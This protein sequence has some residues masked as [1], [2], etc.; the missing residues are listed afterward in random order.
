MLP[1]CNSE[2]KG[3]QSHVMVLLRHGGEIR[4]FICNIYMFKWCAE[5]KGW[6]WNGRCH[7]TG[8]TGTDPSSFTSLYVVKSL[9][10]PPVALR[11]EHVV[12]KTSGNSYT[13]CCTWLSA[14]SANK[15]P[16]TDVSVLVCWAFNGF[17]PL[18]SQRKSLL[19]QRDHKLTVVL[20]K[21]RPT[22]VT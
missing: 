7:N 6:K 12:V 9:P 17:F 19:T 15:H 1:T 21:D 5:A 20:N 10:P 18:S 4:T 16:T 8:R 22:D 13:P 11:L 2:F 14:L 3:W